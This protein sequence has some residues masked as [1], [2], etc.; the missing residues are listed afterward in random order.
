MLDLIAYKGEDYDIG[1][2]QLAN[3]IIDQAEIETR[4]DK[5]RSDTVQAYRKRIRAWLQ[6]RDLSVA[7]WYRACLQSRY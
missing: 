5:E 6:D 4:G 1:S 7:R 2:L 3:A